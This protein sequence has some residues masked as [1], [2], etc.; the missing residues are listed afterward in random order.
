[1]VPQTGIVDYRVVAERYAEVFQNQGGE[2]RLNEKVVDVK[3]GNSDVTVVSSKSTYVGELMVNCAELYSD[4]IAKLTTQNIDV[5]IIPF[6][7]EY[8]KL[9]KEKD[10]LVKT[11]IYPVPDPNFPFLGV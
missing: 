3:L 8:Y 4:K 5:K 7:G 1:H 9:R 6:R 11:L 2:L 10:Y